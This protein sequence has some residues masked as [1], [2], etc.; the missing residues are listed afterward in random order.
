M[1]YWPQIS[2]TKWWTSVWL[3]ELL[4]KQQY[5]SFILILSY[6]CI[7]E[8]HSHRK[9]HWNLSSVFEI[10]NWM[11]KIRPR[12]ENFCVDSN[13]GIAETHTCFHTAAAR[14][15]AGLR[16]PVCACPVSS[17]DPIMKWTSVLDLPEQSFISGTCSGF[18]SVQDLI[19]SDLSPENMHDPVAV[20]IA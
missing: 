5:I 8:R 15:N 3:I 7:Y 17:H 6:S 1:L 18:N 4:L 13:I 10:S 9:W 20:E 16:E 14:V 19:F 11:S 2:C 12:S